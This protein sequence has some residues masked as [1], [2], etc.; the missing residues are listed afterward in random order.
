MPRSW[1]Q[2][3]SFSL[4]PK[5]FRGIFQVVWIR[6]PTTGW[7]ASENDSPTVLIAPPR[8]APLPPTGGRTQWLVPMFLLPEYNGPL[9]SPDLWRENPPIFSVMNSDSSS[10]CRRSTVVNIS[11]KRMTQF[12]IESRPNV[13]WLALWFTFS[14]EMPANAIDDAWT[15]IQ[16]ALFALYFGIFSH[17]SKK[18]LH[19]ARVFFFQNLTLQIHATFEGTP[20]I[21]LILHPWCWSA[22]TS[23]NHRTF[24]GDFHAFRHIT[25]PICHVLDH[26]LC[27]ILPERSKHHRPVSTTFFCFHGDGKRTDLLQQV[28]QAPPQS[29][30]VFPCKILHLWWSDHPH[31]ARCAQCW[32]I[33]APS[34]RVQLLLTSNQEHILSRNCQLLRSHND[35]TTF[36]KTTLRWTTRVRINFQKPRTDWDQKRR[37]LLTLHNNHRKKELRQNNTGQETGSENDAMYVSHRIKILLFSS[38]FYV[39]HMSSTYKD[40]NNPFQDE[41]RDIPNWKFSPFH[42]SIGSSEFASHRFRPFLSW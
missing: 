20:S 24:D 40:K 6:V 41:Q 9:V 29:C 2:F 8:I 25:P 3:W 11:L 22:S 37:R 14:W 39:I 33:Q 17:N 42:V 10:Q 15:P 30:V 28:H 32:K 5:T 34:T 38:Q 4:K 27:H 21:L 26:F 12:W 7:L 16:Q 36:Y 19:I 18:A 23:H 13:H 1:W 31:R 35:M